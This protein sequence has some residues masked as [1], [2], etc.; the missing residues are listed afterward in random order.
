MVFEWNNWQRGRP[1]EE[2]E[3]RQSYLSSRKTNSKPAFGTVQTSAFHVNVRSYEDHKSLR[4]LCYAVRNIYAIVTIWE[5]TCRKLNPKNCPSAKVIILLLMSKRAV[6]VRRV[7][8]KVHI[9]QYYLMSTCWWLRDQNKDFYLQSAFVFLQYSNVRVWGGRRG[10]SMKWPSCVL[11]SIH[12]ILSFH[13]REWRRT[14]STT[15]TFSIW[16][17]IS[18]ASRSLQSWGHPP[19]RQGE[20]RFH[21]KLQYQYKYEQRASQGLNTKFT[22]YGIL[23]SAFFCRLTSWQIAL[24]E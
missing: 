11:L 4:F 6:H 17:S 15:T 1:P 9:R 16:L 18:L 20:A 12:P 5:S 19:G 13:F 23:P 14:N 22:A 21:E 8:N 10:Q 7:R 24:L 3:Y 2:I